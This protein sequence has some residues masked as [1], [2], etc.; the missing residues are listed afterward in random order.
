M[1]PN[2]QAALLMTTA[3]ALIAVNDA[4]VKY[5][6]EDVSVGQVLGIRGGFI[7]V[8]ITTFF[9]VK[10][11]RVFP[12]DL[13][14][15]WNLVRGGTETLATLCFVTS[16]TVLPL[17]V[18]TTLI[19]TSPLV[20]TILAASFL[21]ESVNKGRWMA[22]GGGFAGI[23]L[24]TQPGTDS[25]NWVMMLPLLAAFVGGF[26]DLITRFVSD[27]LSSQHIALTT[28]IMV[29]VLGGVMCLW[30]WYEMEIFTVGILFFSAIC[31]ASGYILFVKAIRL[32]E[33][34][35]VAPFCYSSVVF[36]L[37]IGV[38]VWGEFPDLMTSIG[39]LFIVGAG[40]GMFLKQ[41]GP[42]SDK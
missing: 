23:C 12:P 21:G 13:L 37:V 24:V 31:F 11:Q 29:T 9:F 8:L 28:C 27:T 14:Q 26:R 19:W 36:A 22:V 40:V 4:A 1:T 39:V 41:Q 18:A 7:C 32:G 42:S 16:I 6:S 38:V 5:V 2:L 15:S 25:W 10:K 34:S 35:F 33:L 20:L 30:D 17:A 3:M